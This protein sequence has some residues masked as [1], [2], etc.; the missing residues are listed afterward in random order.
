[1]TLEA[2]AQASPRALER[3]EQ[4]SVVRPRSRRIVRL[5]LQSVESLAGIVVFLVAWQLVAWH[6]SSVIP[7]LQST[8]SALIEHKELLWKDL[9]VTLKESV[10]GLLGSFAV[11]FSLAVLM[12]HVR[13]L[14]RAGMPLAIA[15]NVTPVVSFAP[16]L[17]VAFG[18][19]MVPRYLVTGIIVFFPLLINSFIGLRSIDPDAL[20]VFEVMA[21]SRK[22]VLLKLRIPSALPF[23]F[24]AARICFP[25]S[26]VGAV[27][28]EFTTAQ[29]AGSGGLGSL[30]ETSAAIGPDE[31][32]LIYAAIF[33][34]A[35][36]G[37]FLTAIVV[38]TERRYLFWH[39]STRARV[40]N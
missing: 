5:V 26:L 2:E 8:W 10:V 12:S 13:F 11:A 27:V 28:A 23:L 37:L 9:F 36:L 33:C 40:A 6:T 22:E 4:A 14:E 38:V 19:S 30:I 20:E 3:D 31:L 34:L 21:A 32:G 24:A 15:L 29:L 35:L 1:M 18:F 25:L 17:A 39:A 7:T 16:A